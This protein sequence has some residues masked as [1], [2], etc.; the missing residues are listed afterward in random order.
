MKFHDMPMDFTGDNNKMT[1]NNFT[2]PRPAEEIKAHDV[3]L[4]LTPKVA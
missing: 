1:F 3:N 4:T 2:S